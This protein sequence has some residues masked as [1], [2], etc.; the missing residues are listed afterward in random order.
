MGSGPAST[1]TWRPPIERSVTQR[2]G[3]LLERR[4]LELKAMFEIR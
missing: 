4:E 3:P 1:Q 2:P